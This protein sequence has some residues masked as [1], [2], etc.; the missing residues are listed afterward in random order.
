[1][2]LPQILVV[3]DDRFF[4]RLLHD[5]LSRSGL[6]VV[7]EHTLAGA[8]EAARRLLPE[9]VLLDNQ[10]PDGDGLA[11]VPELLRANE[12]TKVIL[13]TGFPSFDNAVDALRDGVHDYLT[14]PVDLEMLRMAVR[15]ALRTHELERIEQV[16]RQR[17][18]EE[19]KSAV[20][21][22]ISPAWR[23][24]EM[25]MRRFSAASSPV[26][27]TG[28]S[29]TGKSLLARAV[30]YASRR[31][32]G[33]FLAANC[34]ALPEGLIEAELF[35]AEK[36]AY[37]G[38]VT[39]RKGLFE[40]ANGGSLFLDE[41]A[42]MPPPLQAK[43]LSVLE[44]GQ[45]RRLGSTACHPVT[46]CV[47][48]ATNLVPEEAVAT[49]RLR[50]DLFY[51]LNVLRIHIPP[52][53]ERPEDVPLLCRHLLDKLAPGRGAHL[54]PGE[55][56]L[57]AHYPWPGNVRELKNILER[58]LMLQDGADIHPSRLLEPFAFPAALPA[59]CGDDAGE[60]ELLPLDELERRHILRG[61]RACDGN[62]TR[63]AQALGISL[64]TLRRKLRDETAGASN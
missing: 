62:L 6:N 41:I 42:E 12:E 59:A 47:L 37:T 23:Q 46:T 64:S 9:V 17:S 8:R 4:C 49:G 35:G 15:R 14:K 28:E 34:A 33:P 57:L 60:A 50:C 51:R 25:L 26:L 38:A 45:V 44:D 32:G 30:H 10:L 43:L 18:A 54:G 2:R 48:A 7:A 11:L 52:L 5:E 31:S 63:A 3:D 19:R 1:M 21:V 24:V 22:G 36:G 53:R 29:G 27:I 56:R 58:C 39:S 13:I 16:E 40:I 55:E 20:L 61:L